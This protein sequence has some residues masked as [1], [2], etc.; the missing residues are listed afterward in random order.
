MYISRPG[1]ASWIY[2][3]G[4]PG[5]PAGIVGWKPVQ[6]IPENARPGR[7]GFPLAVGARQNQAFWFEIYTR[8][9]LPAGTYE[10]EVE[11]TAGGSSVRVPVSLR[12]FD[13]TLPERNSL[14]AMF[15]YEGSQPELYQGRNLDDL[16]HRFAHLHRVEFVHAYSE[17]AAQKAKGRFDGS[18]F[19]PANGYEGPGEGTGNT[20]LPN[21]FYG[22]GSN[23]NDPVGAAIRS[24]AWMTFVNGF[25]PGAITF[26]SMP[27]EPSPLS[28]PRFAT[29]RP[30]S[31]PAPGPDAAS[32]CS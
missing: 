30:T 9:D 23:F 31:N 6:L 15:Y 3:A 32:R 1:T 24:D 4:S 16:Y 13:F 12:L 27:D 22:P 18:A 7:G 29:S 17:A 19:T 8:R 28:T 14:H 21:T 11:V 20:I 26:V 5:A 2:V 25:L 10:G